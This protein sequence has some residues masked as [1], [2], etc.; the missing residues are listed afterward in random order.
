LVCVVAAEL[1]FDY[2]T[3]YGSGLSLE[4]SLRCLSPFRAHPG[5]PR[6]YAGS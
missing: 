1:F 5:R 3:E 2:R 6:G 4:M